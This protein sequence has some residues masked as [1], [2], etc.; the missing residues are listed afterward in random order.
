MAWAGCRAGHARAS[1]KP[2]SRTH[3]GGASSPATVMGA[4]DAEC[5]VPRHPRAQCTTHALT[6]APRTHMHLGHAHNTCIWAPLCLPH[7]HSHESRTHALA[8]HPSCKDWPRARGW[9]WAPRHWN[10]RPERGWGLARRVRSP[11]L[12][13]PV[14]WRTEGLTLG[15]DVCDTHDTVSAPLALRHPLLVLGC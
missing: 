11:S 3:G 9:D 12:G 15:R 4:E 14:L 8:S 2:A 5:K 1:K 6:T 13:Y 7:Q 10:G